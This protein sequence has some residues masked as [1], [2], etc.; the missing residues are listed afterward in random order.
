[1]S[2]LLSLQ[3]S[4]RSEDVRSGCPKAKSSGE[5]F[6]NQSE[7]IL[8][9]RRS[10]QS[11]QIFS[12]TGKCLQNTA[13]HYFSLQNNTTKSVFSLQGFLH[14]KHLK[15]NMCREHLEV[16]SG[17][18]ECK[19]LSLP[20]I[21]LYMMPD[22]LAGCVKCCTKPLKLPLSL[23]SITGFSSVFFICLLILNPQHLNLQLRALLCWPVFSLLPFL[24][25]IILPMLSQ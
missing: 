19:E 7:N 5:M 8:L 3:P 20:T 16:D 18:C 15:D 12:P 6:W 4:H 11:C 21:N 17:A 13:N 9:W 25:F 22:T 1:M 10:P 2:L 14:M 24:P 23:D